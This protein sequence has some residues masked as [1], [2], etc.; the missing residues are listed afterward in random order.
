MEFPKPFSY[1]PLS[2]AGFDL[3]L[4]RAAEVARIEPGT[5]AQDAGR[6][7][8]QHPGQD[9]AAAEAR[10]LAALRREMDRRSLP[11]GPPPAF[12]L[13][14]LEM[15]QD[16]QRTIARVEAR[17]A[18][19]RSAEALQAENPGAAPASAATATQGAGMAEAKPDPAQRD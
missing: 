11:P 9:R 19:A 8:R 12:K 13:S 15:D 7:A 1:G 18:E 3:P 14:L 17:R 10:D 2:T 5:G 6:E 16:L 4:R